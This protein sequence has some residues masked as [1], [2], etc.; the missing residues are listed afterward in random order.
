VTDSTGAVVAGAMVT[1]IN[2]ATNAQRVVTS[3]EAG[4]FDLPSLPP[5]TYNIRVEKTGFNAQIRNNVVLQVSQVAHFDIALQVGNVT[6]TVEVTGGAPVLETESTAVGTVIENQRIVELPLNGRNYLQLAALT[7]GTTTNSSNSGVNNLR[8]GGTRSLFTLSVSGQRIFY[9]HYTL[10]GIENTDPNWNA[11]IFLPSL[12]A[13]QEFKVETGIFPAEYGH[14]MNQINVTT[15]SGVNQIHGSAFEFLRN[16]ALDAKNYFDPG[17]QPIPPF[18]RNQFGA[19]FGG[20]VV[21]P[22]V[23]HGKDKLFFFVDYEGL[24][25][26]KA[27]TQPATVPP[28]SWIAGNFSNVSTIIY[29]PKTRVL[30]AAGTAVLSAQPFGGNIIPPNRISTISTAYMTKY[31]PQV[32]AAPNALANDFINNEGRPTDNDQQ[33]YRVDYVQSANSNWMFRYSHSGETQYNP[34]NIP[35]Q[36]SQTVDQAHQG[37]LGYT[38]LFGPTVVNDFRTGVSRLENS[39]IPPE[40]GVTNVVAQLGITGI[41]STNPLYWGVPNTVLGGGF[42]GTGN[43]SDSPF[44][45]FD[46]MIQVNDNV[47]W[48]HG[49]HTFKFGGEFTR[50]RFNQIGGVVVRGRFSETGQYSNFGGPGTPSGPANNVADFMMGNFQTVESQTGEP[51]ANYRSSYIG[52]YFE[53]SWKVT[54]KLTINAGLRWEY[55]APWMDKFDN[56]V[57]IDFNWGNSHFPVY[58]RAGNGNPYEGNPPYILPST[59]PLVRDGRFGRGVQKPDYKNFGPRLGIA[60]S[61]NSKTVIRAGGG[62]FYVHDVGNAN[63]DVVR[64]A[65]FTIRRSENGNALIPNLTW[66][67]LF[68]TAGVPSFILVNEYEDPTPRVGQ[69]SFGVQR[70]LSNDMSIE[71]NY[72]G[73]SGMYLQRLITYNNAQPGAGNVNARRPWPIFN[74]GFQVMNGSVHSTYHALQVRLQKRLS[75]GFTL[76]SSFSYAKSIDNGSGLRAQNGDGGVSNDYDLTTIRGLSAFDFRRNWTN[77]LLYELP[78]GKGKAMLGNA[79]R[80]VDAIVGGWQLGT[81]LTLQDGFPLNAGCG[82][83]L[84]NGGDG[85]YPDATGISPQLPRG[86]QDPNRWFNLGA[87]VNRFPGGP[88]FRFGNSGRNTIIG[89]GIIDMD[90]S[91]TKVFRI[92]ER[93]QLQFRAEFFN[94]PNHPLFGQ[95]GASVGTA[96]YGQITS[97]RIDSRQLQFG[98]KY[99]F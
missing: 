52:T 41:D 16:S 46:T 53:D 30:N 13:L 64:N 17:S 37:V 11:Y 39:N 93:Q 19:T 40:A 89:P 47:S 57:N 25:E 49:K 75:Q 58:V 82:S 7:P 22:H 77:S 98:L 97:T 86:E 90:F 73:S 9:N 96:T 38:H 62:M 87:F 74:G 50:T 79:S 32:N 63:F 66:D 10:D 83:N 56:I 26:R 69:W 1:V 23:I 65:P 68:T 76:L 29:D 91:A 14:N 8:Q 60:Y 4:I 6:E 34:I 84:Q 15:R 94:L 81:I 99:L 61:L 54:S 27:L 71:A 51:L 92:T 21:I 95:P 72:I 59:I 67:H 18:K 35:R 20:P 55:Q 2:P 12:D 43:S 85:C 44:I 28:A 3:N 42:S 24:R 88:Q 36:G 80:A 5:G 45:N 70:Q 33:N 31:M 48:T 78:F